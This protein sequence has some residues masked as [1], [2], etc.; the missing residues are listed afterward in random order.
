[1]YLHTLFMAFCAGFLFITPAEVYAQRAV[2]V[3][4]AWVMQG[5]TAPL[6]VRWRPLPPV[7]AWKEPVRPVAQRAVFPVHAVANQTVWN[8][9]LQA[10]LERSLVT[11]QHVNL[12]AALPGRAFPGKKEIDAVIFDLDGTLLD[13]LGAWEHSGSNFV[14]SQGFEPPADLDDKLVAMSLTDGANF[15]KK[16][17]HLSYSPEEILYLTLLPIKNHY[18]TDIDPMPG[19]PETLARLHAQGVKMAVATASDRE[20]AER[21]L[22]RLGLEKYFDF[23]ITCDEVGAGKSSPKI[24]EEALRRLGTQKA[25][26]LVA[27]DALHALQTAHN[28]GFPTAGIEE[29]HSSAVRA[30]KLRAST[31]YVFSYQGKNVFLP[32]P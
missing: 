30:E 15:I 17:Y 25:R 16:Q 22:A 6:P 19:I 5:I 11:P 32:L 29:A 8:I 21:A 1:M 27:E 23:I 26:T 12:P 4:P 28:A 9:P 2:V 13:S 18:Y 14:R 10:R 7:R 24:Y 31:Y 20:L 3:R